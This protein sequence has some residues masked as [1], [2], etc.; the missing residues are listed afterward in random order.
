MLEYLGKAQASFQFPSALE[1]SR[2]KLKKD[3]GKEFSM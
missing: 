1:Y 3:G 2:A